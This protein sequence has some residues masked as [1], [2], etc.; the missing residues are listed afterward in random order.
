MNLGQW[1]GGETRYLA[2]DK[3]SH[4]KEVKWCA[5]GIGITSTSLLDLLKLKDDPVSS[6]SSPMVVNRASALW[7]EEKGSQGESPMIKAQL[8]SRLLMVFVLFILC[9]FYQKLQ[10]TDL[11]DLDKSAK[12][13]RWCKSWPASANK[14]KEVSKLILGPW[15]VWLRGLS[16]GL[17][18]EPWFQIWFPGRSYAYVVGQVPSWGSCDR[19]PIDVSLMHWCFSPS[20]LS[21]SK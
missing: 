18:T 11:E 19:Q 17:W 20:L 10:Q 2:P 8:M 14:L 21:K 5:N 9:C 6:L 13:G 1:G 15:L 4:V 12:S 16:T 7:K 3:L